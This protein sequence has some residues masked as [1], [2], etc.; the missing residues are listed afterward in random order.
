MTGNHG[1]LQEKSKNTSL[2]VQN[3]KHILKTHV[4]LNIM[5]MPW[6]SILNPS[7]TLSVQQFSH[8]WLLIGVFSPSIHQ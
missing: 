6:L 4:F 8:D 5:F 1:K 7:S 2:F 3:K